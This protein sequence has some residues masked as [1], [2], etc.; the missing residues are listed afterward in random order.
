MP[1][2]ILYINIDSYRYVYTVFGVINPLVIGII[3][4]YLFLYNINVLQLRSDIE[5]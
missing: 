5:K 3:I 4:H 1:L 2:I